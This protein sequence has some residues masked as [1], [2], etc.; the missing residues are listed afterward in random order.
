MNHE[1][2]V[3]KNET[4]V[5]APVSSFVIRKL[6]APDVLGSTLRAFEAAHTLTDQGLETLANQISVVQLGADRT[7]LT[8]GEG[9]GL[10]ELSTDNARYVGNIV[11]CHFVLL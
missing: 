10:D 3:L 8:D 11:L 2:E 7:N 6:L 9:G 4:G 1:Y 5:K